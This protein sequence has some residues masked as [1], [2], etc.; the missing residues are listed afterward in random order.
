M[1]KNVVIAVAPTDTA[2]EA[3]DEGIDLAR[4]LGATVHLVHA[5]E[6]DRPSRDAQGAAVST[7]RRQAEGRLEALAT[8][9]RSEN[10]DVTCHALSMDPTKA[11]LRVADEVGADLIVVGNLGAQGARRMLGSVASGVVAKANCAVTVMKTT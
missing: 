2:Y 8:R 4:A 3:L 1:F 9:L 7:A 5:F 10:L 11:I 6:G